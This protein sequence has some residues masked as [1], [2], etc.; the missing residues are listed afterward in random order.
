MLLNRE[1]LK[2]AGEIYKTSFE[3]QK[4]R[5]TETVTLIKQQIP[6]PTETET[7][8]NSRAAGKPAPRRC[9]GYNS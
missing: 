7:P 6:H 5:A 2:T 9:R 3:A 4:N 8:T 1:D